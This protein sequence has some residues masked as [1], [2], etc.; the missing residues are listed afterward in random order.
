MRLVSFLTEIFPLILLSE[1]KEWKNTINYKTE[2]TNFTCN[3]DTLK[4]IHRS[5]FLVI[6]IFMILACIIYVSI[7]EVKTII[8]AV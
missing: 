5:A 3:Q 1:I 6:L 8:Y 2:Q 4:F 7:N